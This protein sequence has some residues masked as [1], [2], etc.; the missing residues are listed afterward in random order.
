VNRKSP[1]MVGDNPRAL[2]VAKNYSNGMFEFKFI[3]ADS[4][5]TTEE[6]IELNR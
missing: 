2:S 5:N 3:L 4:G 6:F 1:M